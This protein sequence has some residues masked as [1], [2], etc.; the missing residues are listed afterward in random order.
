[1]AALWK[2]EQDL[3]DNE[4]LVE[5]YNSLLETQK[6]SNKLQIEVEDH[7]TLRV[8]QLMSNL[9]AKKLIITFMAN[10]GGA[11]SIAYTDTGNILGY[12]LPTE[13]TKTYD[14]FGNEKYTFTDNETG[15]KIVLTFEDDSED[16]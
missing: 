8:L 1:M 4:P 11:I 7:S 5:C 15:S 16:W 3:K 14:S 6:T 12:L 2:S 9:N 10:Q 13:W